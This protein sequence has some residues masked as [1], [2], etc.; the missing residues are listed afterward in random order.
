MGYLA[1]IVGGT[2]T[3]NFLNTY[4]S[5]MSLLALGL[6]VKRWQAVITD[7][8]VGTALSIYALFV[9]DF[10][11]SFIEFLSLMVLWIAPFGGVHLAGMLLRRGRYDVEALYATSGRHLVPEGL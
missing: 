6:K 4:S 1:V 8:T 3:N 9:F 11:N 7:A 5:G 2:T 10:T